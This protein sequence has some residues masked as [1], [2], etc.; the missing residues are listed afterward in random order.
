[1]LEIDLL[2]F[3]NIV[4]RTS[5]SQLSGLKYYRKHKKINI[6]ICL[7]WSKVFF[8]LNFNW[9]PYLATEQF[10]RLITAINLRY[11]NKSLKEDELPMEV[12]FWKLYYHYIF[13]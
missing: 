9:K 10:I 11:N 4:G 6:K 3:I 12:V 8:L 7:Y 13:V 5:G 2:D 1:M